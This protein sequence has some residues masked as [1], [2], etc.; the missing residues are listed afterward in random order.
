MDAAAV[1]LDAVERAA[2][3]Q[4][5]ELPLVEK[6]GV[7][8]AGEV[9]QG[10]ERP[11]G[12]PHLDDARHCLRP[13][14]L[15]ARQRVADRP[16]PRGLLHREVGVAGVDARRQALDPHPPHIVDEHRQPV[17]VI[18]VE[19]HRRGVELDRVVRLQ[20]RRLIA[21]EGI[22]GGVALVEAIVGELGE[23]IEDFVRLALGDSALDATLDETGPLGIHLGLDLLAHGPPKHVGLAQ[24]VT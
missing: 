7:D 20:P 16:L 9:A 23:E 17:G 18:G 1:A 11:G 14:A 13:D 2:A 6:L 22:G 15:E 12:V 4:R 3:D 24:G 19:R 21:D 10:G 8:A 5:L